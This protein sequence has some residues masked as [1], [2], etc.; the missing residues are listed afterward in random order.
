MIERKLK[1]SFMK[2][3]KSKTFQIM[4]KKIYDHL[5]KLVNTLNK[6]EKYQYN[7]RDDLN[8]YGRKDRKFIY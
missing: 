8:Y 6:K 7:D 1:K 2:Q 4:K 5:V 3:E